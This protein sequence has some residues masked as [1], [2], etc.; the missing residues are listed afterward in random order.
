MSKKAAENWANEYLCEASFRGLDSYV[1][2]KVNS[3][4]KNMRAKYHIQGPKKIRSAYFPVKDA[5][6]RAIVKDQEIIINTRKMGT[7]DRFSRVIDN[8]RGIDWFTR[9]DKDITIEDVLAHEM[10]HMALFE[11]FDAAEKQN[12]L[13][14]A[15][16]EALYQEAENMLKDDELKKNFGENI[17]L[18]YYRYGEK[19]LARAEVIAESFSHHYTGKKHLIS[20]DMNKLLDFIAEKD[21]HKRG[22][23]KE[24]GLLELFGVEP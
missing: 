22:D 13:A 2:Y 23:L 14:G 5:L 7:K 19:D 17:Y 11:L 20:S 6:A 1:A 8:I 15:L 16:I 21:W 12:Y 4:I 9:S 10:G 24:S 18:I 3:V